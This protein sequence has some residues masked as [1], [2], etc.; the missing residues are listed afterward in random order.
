[1]LAD[2]AQ[3]SD[4]YVSLQRIARMLMADELEDVYPIVDAPATPDSASEE[5]ELSKEKKHGVAAPPAVVVKGTFTWERGG[6]ADPAVSAA[7]KAGE[8]ADEKQERKGNEA[9]AKK[10]DKAKLKADNAAWKATLS[11]WARGVPAAPEEPEKGPAPFELRDLDLTVRRGAFVAIVGRVASGK[12]SVL[13]ALT[14]DMRRT[15][16]EVTFGGSLAYA[17]QAPWIQVR[18][19]VCTTDWG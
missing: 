16:G 2:S 19:H 13:Q 14:G 18:A 6:K 15:A 3:C 7:P 10:E 5:D 12:S 4:G 11:Q 9:K 1:M 17:P 8:D